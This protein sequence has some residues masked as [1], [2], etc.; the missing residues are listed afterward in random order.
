MVKNEVHPFLEGK[1]TDRVRHAFRQQGEF[2][3]A[4]CAEPLSADS[5]DLRD[6]A[7]LHLA[8]GPASCASRTT[9]GVTPKA[10]TFLGTRK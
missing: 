3:T 7:G 9:A 5:L 6:L 8:L 10:P 2:A 4:V 1:I